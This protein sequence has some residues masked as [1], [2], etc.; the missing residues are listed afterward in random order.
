MTSR[1][2]IVELARIASGEDMEFADNWLENFMVLLAAENPAL[3]EEIKKIAA[4]KLIELE[5]TDG[6][7]ETTA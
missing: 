2:R 7:D 6:Q 5:G 4:E 1:Q 3:T